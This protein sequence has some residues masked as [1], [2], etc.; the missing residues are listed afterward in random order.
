MGIS[1]YVFFESLF[2]AGYKIKRI[3]S[4]DRCDS[5]FWYFFNICFLFIVLSAQKY[6]IKNCNCFNFGLLGVVT[7]L[8]FG[9]YVQF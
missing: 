8:Y 1:K 5:I 3:K 9:I 6:F 7:G 2:I 4:V